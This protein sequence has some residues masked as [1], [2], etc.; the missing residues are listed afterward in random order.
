[1]TGNP[2]ESPWR[3]TP[4]AKRLRKALQLTISDAARQRLELLAPEGRR[5]EFIEGLIM[6]A[7]L[8]KETKHQ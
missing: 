6:A 7:P 4:Q 8:P 3:S 1:M 5:S 2:K